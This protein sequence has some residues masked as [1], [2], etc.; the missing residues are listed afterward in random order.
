VK[1]DVASVY[2]PESQLVVGFTSLGI[3]RLSPA[4]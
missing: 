1:I 4:F 3:V 2:V